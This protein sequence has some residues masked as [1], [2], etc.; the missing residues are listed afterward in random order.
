[1][2]R[3]ESEHILRRALEEAEAE[4]TEE[5]IKALSDAML[6]VAARVMEEAAANFRSG[7]PGGGSQGYYA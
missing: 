7:R 5:Q 4:L 1:M 2:L 6:K 3:S